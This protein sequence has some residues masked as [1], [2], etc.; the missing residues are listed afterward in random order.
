MLLVMLLVLS[1]SAS[2]KAAPPAMEFHEVS[3]AEE[4]ELRGE[5]GQTW[6]GGGREGRLDC[7]SLSLR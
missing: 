7:V 5:R 2:S 4:E 1:L 3:P 6:G